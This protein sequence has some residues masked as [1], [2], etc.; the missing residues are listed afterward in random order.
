MYPYLLSYAEIIMAF[1]VKVPAVGESV[2]E[3]E[4]YQWHKKTGDYADMDEVLVELETD[5]AT[6]EIVAE[7]AGMQ[8]QE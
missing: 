4:I 1:E 5:K 6:V 2:S 7:A 3:G 8:H